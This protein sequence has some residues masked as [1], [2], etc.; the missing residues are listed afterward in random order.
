[1]KQSSADC[2][3]RSTLHIIM[4]DPNGSPKRIGSGCII[5]FD[6]FSAL[7][8][9]A[10]VTDR[11]D[12]GA[13]ISLDKPATNGS[14]LYSVGG[15]CYLAKFNMKKFEEQLEQLKTEPARIEKIDFGQIDLSFVKVLDNLNIVQLPMNFENADLR[16]KGG[17]KIPIL[18]S[19]LVEPSTKKEYAFFGRIKPEFLRL[20]G[21]GDFFETREIYYSGLKFIKKIGHY[22]EF[23]LPTPI[24]D[25]A[26]FQ[27]TSGAPIMDA[28]GKVVSLVTHGYEGGTKIY[29][30]ALS[31]FMA[32]A[33]IM[34][35]HE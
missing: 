32:M 11:T 5:Q 2:S 24:Q 26:D 31:D 7:F 22:Y 15:M 14:H 9:V 27:G 29:G 6:T 19:S 17:K 8:S 21:I 18:F 35:K 28:K 4:H 25:H 12:S 33:T 3:I 34:L 23:E 20:P 30:I 10:H 16:I 1:M 13:C